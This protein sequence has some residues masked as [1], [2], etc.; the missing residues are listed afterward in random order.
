MM[1][2]L[3]ARALKG[4]YV[5]SGVPLIL[6]DGAW[7]DWMPPADHPWAAP[8]AVGTA[9]PIRRMGPLTPHGDPRQSA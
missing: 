8:R 1:A 5:L 3:A 6:E 7:E 9:A 4:S 2:D